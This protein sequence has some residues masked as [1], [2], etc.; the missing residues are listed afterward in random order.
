MSTPQHLFLLLSNKQCIDI[1]S[2]AVLPVLWL[3]GLAYDLSTTVV[4]IIALI[5]IVSTFN[6]MFYCMKCLIYIGFKFDD[7]L[8]FASTIFFYSSPIVVKS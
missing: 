3:V 1:T 5:K 7:I 2:M 6:L 4:S 8:P